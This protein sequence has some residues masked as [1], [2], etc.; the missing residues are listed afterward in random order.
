MFVH[1]AFGKPNFLLDLY[2]E[3]TQ[4]RV[5]KQNKKSEYVMRD[6]LKKVLDKIGVMY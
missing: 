1:S 3:A 5:T 2:S 4:A 6:K